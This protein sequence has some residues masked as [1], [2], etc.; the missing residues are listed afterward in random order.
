MN[1]SLIPDENT[2]EAETFP[3]ISPNRSLK[4]GLATAFF[5]FILLLLG[6]KP[7]VFGMDRSPVIGFIQT[8]AFIT[9]I[10]II[11]LGGC[12]SLMCFWPKG[13]TTITAD[14]GIRFVSTGVVIAVFC[15]MADVF[16]FGTHPITG[17]PFFG[18]LQSL[19]VEIGE[20]I[21]GVGLAMLIMPP[22]SLLR[23][24]KEDRIERIDMNE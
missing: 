11:A 8:A 22:H 19:G 9:G 12:V 3:H 1:E 6:A 2:S 21:I 5:G 16:G 18:H 7:S 23:H 13:S 17:V 14:F 15:G 24:K 4:L 20:A 10:G